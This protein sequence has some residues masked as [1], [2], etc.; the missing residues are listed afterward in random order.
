MDV[1]LRMTPEQYARYQALIE[2]IRK[3][4]HRED[5]T[6]LMLAALEQLALSGAGAAEPNG[7][8][9]GPVPVPVRRVQ[10]YVLPGCS[11]PGAQGTRWG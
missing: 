3:N 4:G 8:T 5:R 6:E 7:I 1:H 11:S 10:G 2:R 9:A